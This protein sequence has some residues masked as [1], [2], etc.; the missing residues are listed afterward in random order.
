MIVEK[1]RQRRLFV[2]ERHCHQIKRDNAED[3]GNDDKFKII[4]EDK[5]SRTRGR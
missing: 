3:N 5:R 2:N 1:V 4:L